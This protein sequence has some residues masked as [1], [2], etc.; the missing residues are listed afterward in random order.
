MKP[1]QTK[2]LV[3]GK[4]YKAN[5]FTTIIKKYTFLLLLLTITMLQTHG[6]RSGLRIAALNEIGAGGQFK[7]NSLSTAALRKLVNEDKKQQI[8]TT[9]DPIGSTK[10]EA[11]GYA[12]AA[13][14]APQSQSRQAIPGP[15]VTTSGTIYDM[16]GSTSIYQYTSL[17]ASFIFLYE[18]NGLSPQQQN[19]SDISQVIELYKLEKGASTRSFCIP[20]GGCTSVNIP[21]QITGQ[22]LHHPGEA[23]GKNLH[24]TIVIPSGYLQPGEYAFID[25]SS[26][27]ADF[28]A[29]NCF[30]FTVKQ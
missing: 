24:F 16:P 8:A 27:S 22:G 5:R 25:K 29:L 9:K 26:L 6:Q 20:S 12:K 10:K 14:D 23:W 13:N 11:P 1:D 18:L 3:I 28:T 7:G 30:A 21:I 15:V 4:S 19:I 17:Q 2:Q